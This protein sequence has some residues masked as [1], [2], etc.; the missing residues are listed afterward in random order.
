[1]RQGCSLKSRL[2]L[3]LPSSSS[4][5]MFSWVAWAVFFLYTL[6]SPGPASFLALILFLSSSI[7]LYSWQL[8]GRVRG[9]N[10]SYRFSVKLLSHW[11][12]WMAT[13]LGWL[14]LYCPLVE[15]A[16]CQEGLLWLDRKAC[17]QGLQ[18]GRGKWGTRSL[19]SLGLPWACLPSAVFLFSL[20][21]SSDCRFGLAGL[22]WGAGLE[23]WWS[24][25]SSE[26]CPHSVW[27]CQFLGLWG[28]AKFKLGLP[29]AFSTVCQVICHSTSAL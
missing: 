22:G 23:N 26:P 28:L 27:C 20:L 13:W 6:Y 25:S 19:A 1:M 24:L 18:E 10:T 3:N 2:V 7:P 17:Q 21:P 12:P 9:G 11:S 29:L 5:S 15:L 16:P 14:S 4:N 8:C